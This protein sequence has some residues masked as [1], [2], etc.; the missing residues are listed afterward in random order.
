MRKRTS[1][2]I[3][4]STVGLFLLSGCGAGVTGDA[5]GTEKW[6]M[7]VHVG[8]DHPVSVE[9]QAFADEVADETDGRIE[10]T[11]R[12]AGELPYQQDESLDILQNGLVE[13]GLIAGGSVGGQEPLFD[14]AGFPFLVRDEDDLDKVLPVFHDHIDPVLGDEHNVVRLGEYVWPAQAIWLADDVDSIDGAAGSK[15]RVF[16]A[17]TAETSE[18]MGMSPVSMP[19]TEV[20]SS[21][22]RGTIDGAWTSVSHAQGSK[23]DELVKSVINAKAGYVYDVFG[24]RADIFESLSE[25]DQTILRDAGEAATE[26]LMDVNIGSGEDDAWAY[27]DEAGVNVVELSES[28]LDEIG[29]EVAP[30]YDGWAEERGEGA[31]ALLADVRE[32]LGR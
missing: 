20:N 25:D 12:P 8:L 32:A 5:G 6:D 28:E 29:G 7:Y 18:I 17:I 13:A 23:L 30:L 3:A 24:V 15:V 26:R 21:L 2:I 16:N 14:I 22:Q 27:M 10:I 11:L 19:A 31:T 9:L 4:A 1:G